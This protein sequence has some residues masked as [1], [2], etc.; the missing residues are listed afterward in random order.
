MDLS[1]AN[2]V[3]HTFL[4]LRMQDLIEHACSIRTEVQIPWDE[5]GKGAVVIE[6]PFDTIY[7][8][9][10]IHGARVLTIRNTHRGPEEHYR[11]HIFDFS[12]R[13]SAALPLSDGSEGGTERRAVFNTGRNC[14]FGEGGGGDYVGFTIAG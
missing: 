5:W 11:M 7:L 2:R 13:A 9:T 6:V 1:P 8:S 14:L 10:I 12:R 4:I 3:P